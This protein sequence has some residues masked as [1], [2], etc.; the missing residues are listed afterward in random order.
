L[1]RLDNSAEAFTDALAAA[2]GLLVLADRNVDALEMRA[3]AL[4]GL[5]VVAADPARVA[6]AAEAFVRARAVTTAEGV[7]ADTRRLLGIVTAH[8]HSGML[9]ALDPD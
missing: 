7:I 4:S 8:D 5:A 1:N 3:L 9:A 2:D 6:E